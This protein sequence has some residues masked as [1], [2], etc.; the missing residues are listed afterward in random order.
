MEP[1]LDLDVA[2][3][4]L[5]IAATLVELKARRLLPGAT[6]RPRRGARPAGRSATCC[7]PACSSARRSRTPPRCFNRL[8]AEAGQLVPAHGRARGALPR[9]RARPA[10]R[11]HRPSGC[12]PRSSR[13]VAPKPVPRVDL[14]HVAP[15]RASVADAVDE[16]RRRAA[17]ARAH[18][19]F[20]QLT[21][22]ARRAARGASSG[23]SPCSSC[24][25]RASSTS[26]SSRPSATSTI[27]WLGAC[28]SSTPTALADIDVYD[29]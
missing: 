25:S 19:R 21:G 18:R 17:R 4:F 26:T 3:E 24:S 22:G 10:R 15:I 9:P 1:A 2:T 28:A 11:R 16:L 23:S 6:T 8:A 7:S 14:D 29:G 13:A 27:A 12:G 20:R 5:L